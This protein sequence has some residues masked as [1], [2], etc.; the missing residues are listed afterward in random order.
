MNKTRI[1]DNVDTSENLLFKSLISRSL[2]KEVYQKPA[3]LMKIVNVLAYLL[4]IIE[5][6][7]KQSIYSLS[8]F[9]VQY[10]Q[11][12]Y[13]QNEQHQKQL[14]ILF[15]SFYQQLHLSKELQLLD[16]LFQITMIDSHIL[17]K[18]YLRLRKQTQIYLRNN[19]KV[20][21]F[22]ESEVLQFDDWTTIIGRIFKSN[23]IREIGYLVKD[24]NLIAKSLEKQK[25]NSIEVIPFFRLCINYYNKNRQELIHEQG[26]LNK[27][28]TQSFVS[29]QNKSVSQNIYIKSYASSLPIVK[30]YEEQENSQQQKQFLN[31]KSQNSTVSH[32]ED[33]LRKSS[34]DQKGEDNSTNIYRS[35]NQSN[36]LNN[37]Q[38]HS[39]TINNQNVMIFH[40]D[41]ENFYKKLHESSCSACKFDSPNIS[42]ISK[43][44]Q[45]Q[46]QQK[47]MVLAEYTAQLQNQM[48]IL[49][50]KLLSNRNSVS[51][52]ELKQALQNLD[53]KHF[54]KSESV[55]AVN[56][57]K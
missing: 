20:H 9:I 31:K 56:N 5:S 53:I 19:R 35:L 24:Y 47:Y 51:D 55:H 27:S 22:F 32:I 34:Y 39:P 7:C 21:E 11:Q 2:I 41:A 6:Y 30:D 29:Q 26:V 17:L 38:F 50:E 46:Q 36:T 15:Y 45:D 4:E 10:Y 37:S 13:P 54:K 43:Q 57:I 33:Y 8:D 48:K 40:K 42:M 12:K 16:K 3:Y 49:L 44:Q 1:L 25:E 28:F 18:F 52:Q 14:T 23:G